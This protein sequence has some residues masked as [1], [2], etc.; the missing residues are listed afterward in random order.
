[1]R[2]FSFPLR[3]S[4]A[5]LHFRARDLSR[6]YEPT[7]IVRS[8][9]PAPSNRGQRWNTSEHTYEYDCSPRLYRPS[10]I[11]NFWFRGYTGHRVFLETRW[12]QCP[13]HCC[14]RSTVI[15]GSVSRPGYRKAWIWIFSRNWLSKDSGSEARHRINVGIFWKREFHIVNSVDFVLDLEAKKW[16]RLDSWKR[17]YQCSY[18][19]NAKI[20]RNSFYFT[21]FLEY[22]SI[23]SE[24]KIINIRRDA[25]KF[26]FIQL[27]REISTN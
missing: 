10:A 19:T 23:R 25:L 24:Q 8:G 1:M 27:P 12:R 16:S 17:I 6:L 14:C 7:P 4:V 26:N 18:V 22:R 21:T 9:T 11:V 13:L 5:A 20:S 3:L 2:V 15:P